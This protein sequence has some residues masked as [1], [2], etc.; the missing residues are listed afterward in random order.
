M[1]YITLSLW[2]HMM[3]DSV[4]AMRY[5]SL[6]IGLITVAFTARITY[7]WFG[8]RAALF[9]S[10]LGA[11]SPILWVFSQEIRAY[12]TMPLF[13]LLLLTLADNLLK[14]TRD[15]DSP[16]SERTPRQRGEGSARRAWLWLLLIELIT[17][18]THNLGVPLI[19]WLNVAMI[20]AFT[21][22]RDL[23]DL[24]RWLVS[25][26]IL[27]ALYLPWLLTQ[28][29]TGTPLN[30]PPPLDAATFWNIW[31]SYFTGIRTMLNA[32]SL[33]TGLTAAFG[34][35]ALLA[36]FSALLFNRS[37]RT[38]LILSQATLVPIFELGIILAAHIDFHPRYFIVGTVATLI[39][40]AIGFEA[41]SKRRTLF[42]LAIL[43]TALFAAMITLR[44]TWLTFSSSVY[45]H[46]DFRTIAERYAALGADDAIIIPYGW[47][48]TLDYYSRKMNFKA[49][50]INIP[51]HA[52]AD[53]IL[54]T[55]RTELSTVHRA[56]F[57]TWYQLPADVRGAYPCILGA[58]GQASN[59]SLTV[60]GL[61]TD[62]YESFLVRD[63]ARFY[64]QPDNVY[65]D[66]LHLPNV[67]VRGLQGIWGVNTFCAITRWQLT[68]HTDQDWHF[69]VRLFSVPRG[70]LGDWE[71]G[72][73]DAEMLDDR[74]LPTS[75]WPENEVA[76]Q[77][78][79]LKVP[80]GLPSGET[81]A[82]P[83]TVSVYSQQ[84][85]YGLNAIHC[86][87]GS[88]GACILYPDGKRANLGQAFRQPDPIRDLQP[89]KDD[90]RLTDGVYLHRAYLPPAEQVAQGQ[91]VRI[92]LELWRLQQ[93][94]DWLNVA[95]GWQIAGKTADV[96]NFVP[97]QQKALA[98]AE[99][100]VPADAVGSATFV[101]GA[102]YSQGGRAPEI[103][104]RVKIGELP[105]IPVKR[106]YSEP[107]MPLTARVEAAFIG[108]DQLIGANFPTSVSTAQP[109]TVTLL[110]QA[111]SHWSSS[112]V[113]FV[114]LLDANGQVIAQSDSPPVSGERPT[115]SWLA[116]EYITDPHT[117]TWKR[118]DYTGTATLE[119]GLYDPDTGERVKLSD[120]T[121]HVAIPVT[122]RVSK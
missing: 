34:L 33:L 63:F 68:R 23:R 101:A 36:L 116:G 70:E 87:Y 54:D 106:V 5:W 6:L 15:T 45:Q 61:K 64:I 10:F 66:P 67:R 57:L 117:L 22:R 35:I 85:P 83:L 90:I 7:Q 95:V 104:E 121:D 80:D 48:P 86:E 55:L 84:T 82:Y 58:T 79:L 122:I 11:I 114:H 97:H 74:Q 65:F 4:W 8:G 27:A 46:D 120:G 40:I 109:F 17:L 102:A 37:R 94:D 16:N 92:M 72:K 98:S 47:E 115:T 91:C 62:G 28:Q 71:L 26:V 39:I 60:Q 113:V 100:C 3:G 96:Q 38:L 14:L 41:L 76:A 19:A 20:V 52:S 108:T 111:R 42:R 93:L 59:D 78:S 50:F 107:A 105:V 43:G 112:A 2:Q 29:P 51:L 13:A 75:L 44:M 24:I 56:E 30:T 49:H 118:Q 18:Y 1:F 77:F 99:L 73:A 89:G 53:T 12:I 119:V 88:D 31:Q 9:A 21:F 69:V 25:Q 103:N 110:W 81:D 32:D